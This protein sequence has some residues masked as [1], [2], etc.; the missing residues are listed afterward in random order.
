MPTINQLIRI[1]RNKKRSAR[2]GARAHGLPADGAASA[3]R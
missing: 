3:P 2:Q 1:G